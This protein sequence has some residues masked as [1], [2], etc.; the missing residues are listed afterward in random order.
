MRREQADN[1]MAA[2][3][4]LI[5]WLSRERQA[6]SAASLK[7]SAFRQLCAC[8]R[9]SQ[10]PLSC[11]LPPSIFN[12]PPSTSNQ[13]APRSAE[14]TAR[15]RWTP[16][17]HGHP[18]AVAPPHSVCVRGDAGCTT[19]VGQGWRDCG[20]SVPSI[21]HP[22][23]TLATHTLQTGP[24]AFTQPRLPFDGLHHCTV[25]NCIAS[26]FEG[27][28]ARP[29]PS[30]PPQAPPAQS[31]PP[32]HPACLPQLPPAPA[33]PPCLPIPPPPHPTCVLAALCR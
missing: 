14:L 5:V 6:G 29:P 4:C 8:S 12:R 3:L 22:C 30:T 9:P 33:L 24:P 32:C 1:E 13:R 25:Q 15:Q 26:L 18:P 17:D 31:L 28:A 23:Q 7:S 20:A 2:V 19:H 16:P 10:L 21:S 11:P 27:S